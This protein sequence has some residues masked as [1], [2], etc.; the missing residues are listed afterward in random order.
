MY[1]SNLFFNFE[2]EN[3]RIS[4]FTKKEKEILLQNAHLAIHAAVKGEPIPTAEKFT[5]LLNLPT[6]AFVSI[7]K[8]GELRGCIGYVEPRKN[9]LQTVIDAAYNAAVNDIRFNPVKVEELEDI[10]IE[11]SVISNLKEIKDISEI[12]VGTH[13]LIIEEGEKIGILLPQVASDYSW[14]RETFLNQTARKAGLPY[15]AWKKENVK[16]YIFTA[17]IINE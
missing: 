9:L 7:Y 8:F 17:D 13:G 12:E 4:V 14:D 10:S 16:I 3:V 6:G 1:I 5:E 15:D 11:I 2:L